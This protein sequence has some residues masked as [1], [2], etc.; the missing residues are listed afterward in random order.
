MKD[1]AVVPILGYLCLLAALLVSWK[2]EP[3]RRALRMTTALL[4]VGIVLLYL[5]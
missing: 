5:A 3:I 4:I 2:A 1:A